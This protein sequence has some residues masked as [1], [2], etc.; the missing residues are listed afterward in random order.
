MTGSRIMKR[1]WNIACNRETV[2]GWTVPGG[3]VQ[4]AGVSRRNGNDMSADNTD[5]TR[6]ESPLVTVTLTRSDLR[7]VENAVAL[8]AGFVARDLDEGNLDAYPEDP[9]EIEAWI[10]DLQRLAILLGEQ[11]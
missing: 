10:R 1:G 8:C 3:T 7:E 5:G 4:L 2:A 9:E 6:D 11:S